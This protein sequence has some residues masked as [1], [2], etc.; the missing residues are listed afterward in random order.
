LKKIL[1]LFLVYFLIVSSVGAH[2]IVSYGALTAHDDGL[3]TVTLPG[4][5]VWKSADRMNSSRREN[6]GFDNGGL[7]IQVNGT[8]L[9]SGHGSFQAVGGGG[10]YGIN[11][12]INGAV[13][14]DS[15]CHQHITVTGG[16]VTEPVS[17]SCIQE[18]N[19]TQNIT[20]GIRDADSPLRSIL[21]F[22]AGLSVIYFDDQNITSLPPDINF[23]VIN[24]DDHRIRPGK[25]LAYYSNGSFIGKF[26]PGSTLTI[27]K[28]FNIS[29]HFEPTPLH[30]LIE[31]EGF[32]LLAYG[33]LPIA[34]I[35]IMGV[36]L[37]II[38][39]SIITWV[40]CKLYK[41]GGKK[42]EN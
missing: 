40:I 24:F 14:S 26:D 25:F 6:M 22:S 15:G 39:L 30:S 20:L 5:D 37:P 3:F 13:P 17:F 7:V 4:V 10:E 19:E 28:R 8:Y 36:I 35:I 33:Y 12:L 18:L 23:T 1:I 16:S 31:A 27:D 32:N 38:I 41:K 42:H 21:G 2:S 34:F 11:A 29:I 9:I